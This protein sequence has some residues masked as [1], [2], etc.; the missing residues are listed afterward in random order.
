MRLE[1]MTPKDD[2]AEA[3]ADA[4]REPHVSIRVLT[5][6]EADAEDIAERATKK[7]KE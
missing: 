4:L 3:E 2:I 1:D 7:P 5:K 6:E